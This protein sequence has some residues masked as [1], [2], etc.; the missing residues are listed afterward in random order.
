[1]SILSNAI[2]PLNT[3]PI[4]PW[5]KPELSHITVTDMAGLHRTRVRPVQFCRTCCHGHCV[6]LNFT[7]RAPHTKMAQQV[8][9]VKHFL[10][11]RLCAKHHRIMYGLGTS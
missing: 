1:M 3:E 5:T 7:I 8:V 6:Q 11:A 10:I 9:V 4:S 2:E